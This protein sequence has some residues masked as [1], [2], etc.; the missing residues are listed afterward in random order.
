M[1]QE[2]VEIGRLLA[3]ATNRREKA[4]FL[5]LCDPEIEWVPPAEWPE[6]ATIRGPEAVWDFM[7]QLD[8]PWEEGPYELLEVV[9]GGSDKVAWHLRRQVRGKTSGVDAAFDYWTV[10]TFRDGKVVRFEWFQDR[11]QALEAGGLRE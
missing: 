4:A 2:N 6:T 9:D 10:T 1:S 5:A 7:V 8:E 3:D 11:G